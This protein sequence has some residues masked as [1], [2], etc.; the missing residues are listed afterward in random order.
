MATSQVQKMSLA[1]WLTKEV[2]TFQERRLRQ[3]LFP[4]GDFNVSPD[5]V[6]K[7]C[8]QLA[9]LILEW[10]SEPTV[11][12]VDRV[13]RDSLMK[14]LIVHDFIFAFH[15]AKN[16]KTRHAFKYLGRCHGFTEK[17]KEEGVKWNEIPHIWLSCVR[18]HCT[19]TT[20]S[21]TKE[22]T[23]WTENVIEQIDFTPPMT[24]KTGKE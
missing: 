15:K 5:L 21:R 1:Q 3:T 11:E 6:E 9:P 7:I 14:G 16:Q 4:D 20:Y 13:L 18:E 23:E 8:A 10:I 24:K 17:L 2:K 22:N 12:N 19:G